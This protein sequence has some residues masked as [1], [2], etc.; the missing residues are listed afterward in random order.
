M[1]PALL[2]SGAPVP[3]PALEA[4]AAV[5]PVA[6]SNDMRSYYQGERAAA[7]LALGLGVACAAAGAPLVAQGSAFAR[8]L[9]VPLLSLGLL[10]GAG[11]LL[12]AFQVDAEIRRYGAQL[13]RDPSGFRATELAHLAGTQRRFVFYRAAEIALTLAGVG[14]SAYGLAAHAGAFAGAGAGLFAVGLPFTILDAVNDR[15]AGTYRDQLRRFDPKLSAGAARGGGYLAL[16]GR[17]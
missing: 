7:Y 10:E 15:R 8:G 6:I 17:Y 4:R 5:D 12:Y 2:L 14:L 9:G 16:S 13:E 3:P 1:L 11:A